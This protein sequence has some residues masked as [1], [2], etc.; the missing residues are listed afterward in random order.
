[1]G[2]GHQVQ[3]FFDTRHKGKFRLYNLCS[4]RAYPVE[5]FGGN[6]A[7]FPFDDHNPCPLDMVRVQLPIETQPA[8]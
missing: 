4:E 7:R 2:G 5:E 6:V 1:M 8:S 3:T